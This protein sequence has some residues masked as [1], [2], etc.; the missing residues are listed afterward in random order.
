M[1]QAGAEVNAHVQALPDADVATAGSRITQFL[2]NGF[3]GIVTVGFE[4]AQATKAA[5]EANPTVP[6]AIVDFPSQ[7]PNMKGILFDVAAP[8]FM[9][10]YLAAGIGGPALCAPM[11]GCRHRRS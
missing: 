1:Q 7:A 9:A 11:A 4:M 5:A 6:F 3:D 8:S 10:G 2:N